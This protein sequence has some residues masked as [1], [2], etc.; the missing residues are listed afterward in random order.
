MSE[1]ES[2]RPQAAG[3]LAEEGVLDRDVGQERH[4]PRLFALVASLAIVLLLI[5]RFFLEGGEFVFLRGAGVVL[6]ALSCVF[7]FAPFFLLAR[8]G[9]R[10]GGGTYMQTGGVV[11]RGLYAI[12]RHPQY[13]GYMLLA[14][15]FALLSQHWLAIL[16]AALSSTC[17]YL[18]AL[19]EEKYCLA[20][21]GAAYEQYLQRV[22]RFNVLLGIVRLIRTGEKP[23]Q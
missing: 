12:I 1:V 3:E 16:L 10:Q 14:C 17:F 11:E 19:A 15:G 4:P 5:A 8:H 21:F 2:A 9:Q 20:Q 18:Q 7:I 23:W 13:L 22:P 6:L